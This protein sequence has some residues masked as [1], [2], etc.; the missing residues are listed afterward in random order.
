M[1]RRTKEFPPQIKP[2]HIGWYETSSTVPAVWWAMRYW[3]GD[4][5]M[6]EKTGGEKAVSYEQNRYWRGLTRPSV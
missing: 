5:W 1:K 2:V 6:H 4:W 3:S